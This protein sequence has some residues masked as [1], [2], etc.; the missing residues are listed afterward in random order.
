LGS[1]LAIPLQ[2]DQN[3][4]KKIRVK[5]I[6][7]DTLLGRMIVSNP[8]HKISPTM[9]MDSAVKMLLTPQFAQTQ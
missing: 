5:R 6:P 4:V 1:S 8:S 7:R 2:I 9:K 3:E